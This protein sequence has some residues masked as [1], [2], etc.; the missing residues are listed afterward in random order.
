MSLTGKLW[1]VNIIFFMSFIYAVDSARADGDKERDGN[2]VFCDD[3]EP[4]GIIVP[5]DCEKTFSPQS[6]AA[7]YFCTEE[8]GE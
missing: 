1:I 7:V 8:D 4:C 5:V 2:I 6:G 3:G